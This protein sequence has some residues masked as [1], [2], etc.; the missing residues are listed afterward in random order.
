MWKTRL[1]LS[2]K[3]AR[4]N[5][6]W[7][8]R[9]FVA[10]LVFV[11]N[12]CSG[13]NLPST[14]DPALIDKSFLTQKPCA[15]PCWYGLEIDKSTKADILAKLDEL[16]FVDHN[17]YKEYGTVWVDDQ[18]AK[19]I[20][21]HCLNKPNEI[22]GGTLI[23][24]DILKELWFNIGYDLS[25]AQVVDKIGPPDF[26]EYEPFSL[27]GIC[28]IDLVWVNPGIDVNTKENGHQGCDSIAMAMEYL[29]KSQWQRLFIL[30]KK[31]LATQEVVVSASPGQVLP[32]H[33]KETS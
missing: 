29:Q 9:L 6:S 20:R 25:F 31:L 16:T 33:R 5:S 26:V 24:K 3:V 19:E 30:P 28:T 32:N 15:A 1:M 13:I 17:T 12:G 7:T 11:L 4:R 23:S 22:C 10:A 8:I 27:A 14:T 18:N 2:C 21:F